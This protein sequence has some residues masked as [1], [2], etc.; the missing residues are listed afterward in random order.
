ML[1]FVEH[2]VWRAGYVPI[3]ITRAVAT[4]GQLQRLLFLCGA[5]PCDPDCHER[6]VEGPG[7]DLRNSS[8]AR[9]T[10]AARPIPATRM[11]A[12]SEKRT[13]AT[14]ATS[15]ISMATNR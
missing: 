3:G 15:T 11:V 4:N 8:R 13:I 2:A 5:V 12:S 7:P 1:V 10:A 6:H 9:M 14:A